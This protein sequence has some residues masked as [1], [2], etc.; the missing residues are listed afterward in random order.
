MLG[1]R[2]FMLMQLMHAFIAVSVCILLYI[3]DRL[4][5]QVGLQ[6]PSSRTTRRALNALPRSVQARVD[7]RLPHWLQP[8]GGDKPRGLSAWRVMLCHDTVVNPS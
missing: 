1:L 2:P 5:V 3:L 8:R 7:E 4:I 6:P